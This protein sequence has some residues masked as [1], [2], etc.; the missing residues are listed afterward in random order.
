MPIIIPRKITQ[1]VQTK[2]ITMKANKLFSIIQILHMYAVF[3]IDRF[4]YDNDDSLGPDQWGKVKDAKKNYWQKFPL[5]KVD[6]NEC[7]D[8]DGQKSPINIKKTE[9]CKADHHIFD[10]V[11][12]TWSSRAT[13][14]I[15][16]LIHTSL[17]D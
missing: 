6:K 9:D 13:N 10:K 4:N 3:G 12:E 7:G 15:A 11:S 17:K 2:I 1:I 8:R 14:D 16:Y 5:M